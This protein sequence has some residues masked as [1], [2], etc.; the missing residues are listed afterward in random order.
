MNRI[1]TLISFLF[2]SL[3]SFAE[4]SQARLSIT[5]MSKTPIRVIIDGERIQDQDNTIRISNLSPGYHRIQIYLAGNNQR[6]QWGTANQQGRMIYNG[7]VNAQNGMHTDIIVN[8]FGRV[9]TDE[10]PVD[11]RYD[12]EWNNNGSWNNND[13]W[14]NGSNNSTGWGQSMNNERFQQL[15]QQV[16]K[17]SFDNNRLSMLKSVLPNNYV[18]AAQVRELAQLFDFERNKLEFAKF[19]YRYTADRRNYFLVNDVFDFS[20]SKTELSQYIANYRD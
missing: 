19:A 15:K 6:R 5:S 13:G 2:F 17:E 12:D 4:R 1:F 9:F 11:N 16:R 7:T 18:S 20:N 8:R 14:N 10:Q 3:S